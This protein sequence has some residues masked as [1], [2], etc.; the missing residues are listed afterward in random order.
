MFVGVVLQTIKANSGEEAPLKVGLYMEAVE[1]EVKPLAHI[2]DQGNLGR[3]GAF[4]D[5]RAS[6]GLWKDSISCQ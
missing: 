5:Q 1:A 6:I 2:L 3:V 4:A